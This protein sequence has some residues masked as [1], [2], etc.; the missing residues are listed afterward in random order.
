MVK[1]VF[2]INR[3][4]RAFDNSMMFLVIS[5]CVCAWE[6]PIAKMTV[7]LNDIEPS[8]INSHTTD[9]QNPANQMG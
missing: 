2:E 6:Q 9:S 8:R 5:V 1:N 4:E 7:P 3:L